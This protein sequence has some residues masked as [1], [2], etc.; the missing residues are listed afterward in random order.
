MKIIYLI[1]GTYRAA[2][3][4]RVLAEKANWFAARDYDILIITSEQKGRTPAFELDPRIRCKD[5]AIGY[6]DNNGGSFTD[7]LFHYPQKKRKHRRALEAVL[8]QEK[9]DIVVS[10]FGNEANILPFCGGSSVTLPTPFVQGE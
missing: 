8:K 6:E 5:L 4:E 1:P 2:G 7:K 3:M 10:M 9:A